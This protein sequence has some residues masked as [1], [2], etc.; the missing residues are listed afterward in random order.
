MNY[1][2]YGVLSAVLVLVIAT[3]ACGRSTPEVK[4]PEATPQPSE[5]QPTTSLAATATKRPTLTPTTAPL[6]SS[7]SNPAPVGA[8]VTIDDMTF[9][10]VELTRPADDIVAAGNM[11]Y[12]KPEPGNEYAMVT[13]S[14]TCNKSSDETC[15]VSYL[16]FKLIGSSGIV[17][18]PEIVAGVTGL[19]KSSK[20]FG[21]VTVTGKI[22][23]EIA[24]DETNLILAYKPFL[25]VSEA[26]LAVE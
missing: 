10:V 20:F 1:R 7:R 18:E 19:L 4:V 9:K 5:V 2:V 15:R 26:Y 3:L 22:I 16:D 8:E 21:G 6:G 14:V 12:D 25:G 24:Q 13:I 11:F 23:F 17:R